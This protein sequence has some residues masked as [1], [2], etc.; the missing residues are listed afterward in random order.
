MKNFVTLSLAAAVVIAAVGF[1][2]GVSAT[3]TAAPNLLVNPG[4]ESPYSKQCCHTESWA[5]PTLPIDEVQVAN[6]W[7]AWWLEPG[8]AAHPTWCADCPAWHRPEWREAAPFA[9]RIHSGENAQKYFTF[10]STHEAG[11][12]Q[13]VSGVTP[14]RRYRFTVYMH[15]WSANGSSLTSTVV[16]N[17]LDMRVGIDPTGGANPFSASIAWSSPFNA[18]DTWTLFTVEVVAQSSTLT[19]YTHTKPRWGMEHN[20]VYVDDASLIEVDGS[21]VIAPTAT[22]APT[23]T[24]T[25]TSAAAPTSAPAASATAG[26][27]SAA[28]PTAVPTTIPATAA[29]P[30]A[31]QTQL[32]NYTLQRGDTLYSVALRYGT[33]ISAIMA[34]NSIADARRVF[35]GQVI[36][37][38]LGV[39][40]SPTTA[41]AGA[42]PT[43]APAAPAAASPGGLSTYT[44][45][46]GDTL[47][48]I[49][50]KYNV[51]AAAIIA[52]NPAINP[53]R[54]FAGQVINLPVTNT[55][56][57]KTY[58]V[59]R[60]DT[61]R[62]I[63]SRFGTTTAILQSLNGLA[64]P[65]KIFVGQT[66]IV[67]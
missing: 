65:N 58:V 16:D 32:I 18:Y 51:T 49:G 53:S 45:Q 42:A 44:V 61:L 60:G 47:F 37:L 34:V 10:Y 33:S 7:R 57:S 24:P 4:F 54:I 31:T 29:A 64:D 15:A 43:T 8:D 25:A 11:M 67:P 38:P 46:R 63:A 2:Q 5:P 9:N 12:Y 14:G 19:V 3:T 13:Q 26:S 20:D 23:S 66:L 22:S 48:S 52:V 35:A 1:A 41:P 27:A 50:R 17:D 40:S 62:S 59:Q 56:A 6:G 28:S 21:A 55:G 36:R 39:N 30:T